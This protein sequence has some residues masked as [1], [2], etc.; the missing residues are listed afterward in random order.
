MQS[1]T[2]RSLVLG[3]SALVCST[4]ASFAD[5]SD[6]IFRIDVSNAS[7]SGFYEAT[8]DDADYNPDLNMWT[9]SDAAIPIT[10]DNGDL[11]AMLDSANTSIIADP[12]ISLGFALT[13]GG[14]DTAV[15]ISS[16]LLSFPTIDPADASASV[17]VTATDVDGNTASVT[18]GGPDGGI[19]RALYNGST[20]FAE[21]ITSVSV[22]DPF[23]SMSEDAETGLIA[24]GEPVSSMSAEFSFTLSANDATSATSV[25]A[26]I[27]E[28]ASLL[29]LVTIGAFTRRR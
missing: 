29:L 23:D 28:P 17:G 8:L 5:V 15:T 19:Y 10:D 13:A 21:L 9:W 7:G 26:V 11:I 1:L 18:G 12:V 24:V 20:E 2:P 25:F 22:A 4:A 3:I 27:P 16:A 6:I 14:A